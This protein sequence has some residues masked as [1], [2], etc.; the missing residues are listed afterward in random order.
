[1][2]RREI[3]KYTAAVTGVALAAP[4]ASSVLVGCK[5]SSSELVTND[6]LHFFSREEFTLV[7][8]IVD[9]ILPKT[10][11]PSATEVGVDYMIDSMVGQVYDTKAKKSYRTK[12]DT[13]KTKL[14]AI[15]DNNLAGTL[16][17]ILHSNNAGILIELK[18]QTVAYYL[19]TEEISKN[20]LN[21]LPIPGEYEGCIEL[22]SVNNK[23]WAI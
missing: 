12:F 16:E 3:I 8:K 13:L 18:Q 22:S 20:H 15:D 9:V 1:M 17:Q 23:A 6:I 4:I 19:T 7:S 5:E 11:S 21:Y 14:D 2:T 10:D